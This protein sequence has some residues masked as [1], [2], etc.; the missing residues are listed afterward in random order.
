MRRFFANF[1]LLIIV[2]AVVFF[3]GWIQFSVKPGTC[4]VLV[5]KT[6]G[7]L[8]TPILPGKFMWRWEKL[9]PTN[10]NLLIFS[11]DSYKSNQEYSGA[12]PSNELYEKLLDNNVDFS[13]DIKMSISLSLSPEV[14]V[15]K[16]SE[17]EIKKQADLESF[18]EN[19]AMILAKEIAEYVLNSAKDK[20][21]TH[22]KALDKETINSI[23]SRNRDF[24]DIILN[25][26]EFQSV[27]IPDFEMYENAKSIYNTYKD[28]LQEVIKEKL[29]APIVQNIQLQDNISED[30]NDNEQQNTT[31]E[32]GVKDEYL[33]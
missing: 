30:S 4:G 6:S 23:I 8:E 20:V 32:T 21:I 9:L 28:D 5:S 15:K 11:M 7:V 12:L 1:F 29:A 3:I 16:V 31:S 22:P 33:E 27:K 10:A 13:Y 14:I 18:L 17:N 26:V 2:A 24:D 19:K 25:S